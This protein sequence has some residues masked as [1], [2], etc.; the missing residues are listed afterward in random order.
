MKFRP[1]LKTS[2]AVVFSRSGQLLG[3]I[4]RQYLSIWQVATGQ[5][6]SRIKVLSDPSH[7][8]F[9]PDDTLVVVKNTSGEIAIYDLA[10]GNVISHFRPEESDEGC[11]IYFT[12]DGESLIDGSWQGD[13]NVRRIDTFEKVHSLAFEKCQI[14]DLHYNP[15]LKHFSF[16]VNAKNGHP[17]FLKGFDFIGL[18]SWPFSDNS[19]THFHHGKLNLNCFQIS[20]DGSQIVVLDNYTQLDIIEL[21]SKQILAKSQLTFGGSGFAL[22]WSS[23][24]KMI[25]TLEEGQVMVL[26]GQTLAR[27]R[28]IPIDYPCDVCFSPTND[29]LAIGSWQNGLV[30]ELK[31]PGLSD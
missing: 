2:F 13:L 3:T 19:L 1:P 11:Q 7:I 5:R 9:S 25:A 10:T 29:L 27:L 14:R 16:S 21:A 26:G 15:D 18:Y 17:Q 8:D 31:G 12:P 28:T 6:T 22:D 23:D 30:I 24:G 4:N 20:P